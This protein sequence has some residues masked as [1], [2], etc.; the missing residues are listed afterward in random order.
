MQGQS[1]RV[2]SP[3]VAVGGATGRDDLQTQLWSGRKRDGRSAL[4]QGGKRKENTHTESLSPAFIKKAFGVNKIFK[5][6]I[7]NNNPQ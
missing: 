7:N 5:T 3:R 4:H 1:G 2:Q 6:Q